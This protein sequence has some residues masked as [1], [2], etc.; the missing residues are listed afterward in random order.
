TM[1]I[2]ARLLRGPAVLIG[3]VMA[4]PVVAAMI[5][6]A[7][8]TA[9]NVTYRSAAGDLV[10]R[11]FLH[12]GGRSGVRAGVAAG[13]ASAHRGA[14]RAAPIHGALLAESETTM[15]E[16][17]RSSMYEGNPC[18]RGASGRGP[19]AQTSKTENGASWL[20]RFTASGDLTSGR[21]PSR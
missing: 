19:A 1:S 8:Q 3:V 17:C 7:S 9:G 10:E 12:P 16:A 6:F 18:T 20:D 15:A 21:A 14:S 13:D 4:L 5:F 11:W 2:G